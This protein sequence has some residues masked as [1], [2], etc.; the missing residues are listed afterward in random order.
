MNNKVELYITKH[1][2]DLLN[3]ANKI[4]K[5]H[6]L[7][8]ELLH[9]VILQLYDKKE[10]NLK[11]Y[12]DNSIRYYITAVM[13][14]NYYSKTS[15]FYYRIKKESETYRDFYDEMNYTPIYDFEDEEHTLALEKENLICILENE[16]IELSW[17]EKSIF[18]LYIVMGSIKKVA[19]K[20]NIPVSGVARYVKEIRIKIKN[21]IEERLKDE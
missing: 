7:S 2:Y 12:C 1:Y 13:K 10:I 19:K 18:D 11:K 4:T 3:I 21:N 17:F 20:T 6:E 15:P 5:G 8:Q 16:Y 9:E 14:I